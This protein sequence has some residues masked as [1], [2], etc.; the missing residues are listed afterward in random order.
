[1]GI[2]SKPGADE[3][4]ATKVGSKADKFADMGDQGDID[5]DFSAD[6]EKV[7]PGENIFDLKIISGELDMDVINKMLSM[8]GINQDA[9]DLTTLVS[10]DFL[11]HDTNTT[12]ATQG[13]RPRYLSSFSFLNNMD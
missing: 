12:P 9:K 11:D 6:D 2:T 10:I 5:S 1:M 8:H 3:L 13:R 4:K 7:Q